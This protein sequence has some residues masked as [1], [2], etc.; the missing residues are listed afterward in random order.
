MKVKNVIE[1]LKNTYKEDEELM[2]DWVDRH[3]FDYFSKEEWHHLDVDV[4][5]RAV[6]AMEAQSVG[7]TDMEY[8]ADIIE[9]AKNEVSEGAS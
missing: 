3:Q 9:I 4:W 8:V 7:M 2:I 1:L 5:N 6:S